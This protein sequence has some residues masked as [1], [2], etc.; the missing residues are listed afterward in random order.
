[1][2][3]ARIRL[4][5]PHGKIDRR[6]GSDIHEP[7]LGGS[8]EENQHRIARLP[9]QRLRQ[10]SLQERLNFSPAPQHHMNDSRGECTVTLIELRGLN[11]LRNCFIESPVPRKYPIEDLYRS[12]PQNQPLRRL[13]H[14]RLAPRTTAPLRRFH[15]GT[16]RLNCHFTRHRGEGVN[17]ILRVRVG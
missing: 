8:G 4:S 3:G 5:L 7:Q 12:K 13:F 14:F 2:P 10:E 17:P 15:P 16:G 1:M 11:R 9:G 6:M